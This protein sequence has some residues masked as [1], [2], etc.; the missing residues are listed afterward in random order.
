MALKVYGYIKA[1]EP[2]KDGRLFSSQRVLLQNASGVTIGKGRV[3]QCTRVAPNA[4]GGWVSSQRCSYYIKLI[5]PAPQLT[6]ALS[7]RGAGEGMSTSCREMKKT[8][9]HIDFGGARRRKRKAR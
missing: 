8:P 9:R 4:P 1:V 5:P 7:C 2:T 6:N 3:N